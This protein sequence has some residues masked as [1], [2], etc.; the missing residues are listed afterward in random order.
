MLFQVELLRTIRQEKR[1][2]SSQSI[3]VAIAYHSG[4]GHTAKQADAVARGARSVPETQV[5][6]ID[7]QDLADEHWR[8][9]DGADAIVFGAPTYMGGPSGVFKTFADATAAVW[10]EQRWRD[11][12][13]AGFTNSGHMQ[14]DKLNTLV[15]FALLAAQHGMHWVN[16]GL[17]G[18]WDTSTGSPEDLNRLGGWLGAMA[19]SNKD[20]GA[21]VVPP[22]SDLRTAEAL[23]RRVASVAHQYARGRRAA[24]S[25]SPEVSPAVAA[26]VE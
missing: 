9:L 1:P 21:D 13:A 6:M 17:K 24:Q 18:G 3:R 7:V 4:Y 22:S 14:G 5:T 23:G 15:S 12:L 20:Q 2:V 25:S 26:S 19:Q 11:K 8:L 10:V 16:L